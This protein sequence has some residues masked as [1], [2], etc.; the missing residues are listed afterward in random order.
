MMATGT[1]PQRRQGDR[2][3]LDRRAAQRF[4]PSQPWHGRSDSALGSGFGASASDKPAAP[5]DADAGLAEL[6][7]PVAGEGTA[8]LRI[9]RIY[10]VAR[11]ALAVVLVLAPWAVLLYGGPLPLTVLL[12]SLAYAGQALALWLLPGL[13]GDN[14]PAPDRLSR[15]QWA[16]TIGVDMA[17]FSLLRLVDP[18]SHLNY[19]ALLV[20]P[21]LMAGVL[22]RRLTALASAAL[23]TLVLLAGA[24]ISATEG[25][26]LL[27]LSQAGLASAGL[28]VITVLTS[29][30][31]QRLATEERAARG[32]R[33]LAYQQT[34]LNRVVIEEMT[35]GV[36][37]VD[38]RGA[39]RALNPA[40]QALLG[41]A[42][43]RQ[44]PP[45][46][47]ALEPAWRPLQSAIAD[48]FLRGMWPDDARELAWALPDGQVCR[49]Q[50]RVRFTRRSGIG[51]GIGS[52]IRPAEDY[53]VLFLEEL[54]VAQAR[55]RQEKLAA[56]GRMSAGIAHE[57]RNP[58]AAVAQANA[59]LREYGLPPEHDRLAR[60]V[61]AN[62]ERL[63]RIVDDVMAVAPGAT[64]PSASIDARAE[65]LT[66]C[67]D[68][69]GA[70]S[71][72]EPTATDP[73]H[74][75]AADPS[76][77]ATAD[78]GDSSGRLQLSLPS[79]PVPVLFD[80]EHLRRV[81]VNLLDNAARHASQAPGAIRLWLH[82][83][84][85]Q[86]QAELV[87]ASDGPTIP[88]EVERY[89]FEPFFSTRSRGSGLGLYIC[90]E[91]CERHGAS[92]E[93][94]QGAD[95]QSQRNAFR[96]LLRCTPQR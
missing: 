29:E 15:S 44:A 61:D 14:R 68:W 58:L 91:L 11:G 39:V 55:S 47:L 66:I 6:G 56:M 19:A 86:A 25:D 51:S 18:T 42:S 54:R 62:V 76:Q 4:S 92:I 83:L 41:P 5:D 24:L 45:F 16:M 23:V 94:R 34:Q 36:L 32:N 64:Q 60:I 96:V 70:A 26:V 27:Q 59:L 75:G 7:P 46:G 63:K 3:Q 30:L 40:A 9:L 80:P 22:T 12:V 73:A 13:A 21:V 69:L 65:L 50:V 33:A 95:G 53:C 84:P 78:L 8:L 90:R 48:A 85:G 49:V 87:V 67:Q 43:G 28:F 57:I 10:V 17:T 38:Q 35:E 89:L 71:R 20:L 79:S 72:A 77:P 81:L 31:A 52:G 93:Y 82:M 88:P 2:R 1:P 37:V 74:A